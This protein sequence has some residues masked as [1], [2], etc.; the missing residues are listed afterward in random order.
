MVVIYQILTDLS[1]LPDKI[2]PLPNFDKIYIQS[3]CAFSFIEINFKL[4]FS[5]FHCIILLLSSPVSII[6]LFN[7]QTA[8]IQPELS[9]F[10]VLIKLYELTFIIDIIFGD[11]HFENFHFEKMHFENAF[12]KNEFRKNA[13]R[14]IIIIKK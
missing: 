13:F 12:R 5:I 1:R 9:T 3:S 10:I 2:R 4:S 8:L 6:S 7:I 11:M 14:K